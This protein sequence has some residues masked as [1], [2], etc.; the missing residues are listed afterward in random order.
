MP[1]A[2]ARSPTPASS[3]GTGERREVDDVYRVGDDQAVRLAVS[4]GS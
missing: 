4:S 3:P 1:R 2:A